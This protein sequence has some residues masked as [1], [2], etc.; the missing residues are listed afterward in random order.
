MISFMLNFKYKNSMYYLHIVVTIYNM[1]R[2]DTNFRTLVT[3]KN[4]V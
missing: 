1:F 2:N 4:E 3:R